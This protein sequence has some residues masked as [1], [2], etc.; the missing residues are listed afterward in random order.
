MMQ[1]LKAPFAIDNELMQLLEGVIND[2][3]TDKGQI[4]ENFQNAVTERCFGSLIIKPNIEF[5]SVSFNVIQNTINRDQFGNQTD[6]DELFRAFI[7]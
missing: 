5:D 4:I 3:I 1:T 6:G 2:V 7:S